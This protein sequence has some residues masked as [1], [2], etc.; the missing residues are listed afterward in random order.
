MRA[1]RGGEGAMVWP[2]VRYRPAPS[3]RP[4]RIGDASDMARIHGEG[5]HR[6]WSTLEIERLLTDPAV[7]ADAALVGGDDGRLAGFVLSRRAADEAEVLT[8]AM[9]TRQRGNGIA[10]RLLSQHMKTLAYA[11]TRVLFLEVDEGNDPALALYRRAGFTE[12]GRRVAY[13]RKADG[14]AATAL[15][16]RRSL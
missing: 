16:L 15:V 4:A 3:I 12:V 2:F 13:Y 5:F 10:G 9:T 7:L 8:I 14:S 11:G 6:A 1:S